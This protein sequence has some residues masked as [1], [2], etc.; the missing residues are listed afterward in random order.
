LLLKRLPVGALVAIALAWSR[1]AHAQVY[2]QFIGAET[3]PA[4]G[5]LFGAYAFSS[6]NVLGLLAQ[7]RLSFYPNVDFGFHGGIARQDFVGGNRTTLR[8]GTG[9]KVKVSNANGQLPVDM[10]V[11][12]DLGVET[13]DNFHLLTVG[14]TVV[15][16]RFFALG[17]N[18]GVTPY[19]RVGL[20]ITN[21]DVGP[22]RETDVSV[23]LRLGGDFR[24]TPELRLALELQ[25]QFGDI[26]NDNVGLAG[27]VNLPF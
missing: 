14:P 6:E 3:V 15:A 22:L 12:G 24:V 27:G 13:G 25:L 2:G 18:G 1:L 19:G 20:A 5:R 4:G 26:F 11:G 16:S 9:F 7:L 17:Q 23:P 10:A 8:L 21:I